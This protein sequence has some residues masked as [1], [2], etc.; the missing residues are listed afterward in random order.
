MKQWTLRRLLA[1][2]L[3]K[4]RSLTE[5]SRYVAR[6]LVQKRFI[7]DLINWLNVECACT[8]M[9]LSLNN[10]LFARAVRCDLLVVVM[11]SRHSLSTDFRRNLNVELTI[12]SS[13]VNKLQELCANFYS[14]IATDSLT[15]YAHFGYFSDLMFEC[16]TNPFYNVFN[17][18][19][20]MFTKLSDNDSCWPTTIKRNPIWW[21]VFS[22]MF[23]KHL[24]NW[25]IGMKL[26]VHWTHRESNQAVHFVL[27]CKWI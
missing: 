23:N 9:Y 5:K 4:W 13:S 14:P 10:L 24:H 3:E 27:R 17:D 26:C 12:P 19:V 21:T 7:F 15:K 18:N 8:R 20:S 2:F 22:G 11:F 1:L 16:T 6:E 25:F